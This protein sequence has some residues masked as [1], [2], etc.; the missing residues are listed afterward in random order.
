[1]TTVR[2]FYFD[3]CPN[4]QPTVELAQ[5]VIAELKVPAQVEEVEVR[6][7]ED[8]RRLRFLG[9]PSVQVDGVDIDPAARSQTDF[10]YGCRMYCGSGVPPRSMLVAALR[11]AVR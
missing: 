9:S 3:G 7:I 5:A 11:R 1:M 6:D 2:V 8:A 10:A 4:H